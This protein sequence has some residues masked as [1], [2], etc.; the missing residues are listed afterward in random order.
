MLKMYPAFSISFWHIYFIYD[1]F[2][3]SN[4]SSAKFIKYKISV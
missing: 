3:N 4:I 1:I 2:N